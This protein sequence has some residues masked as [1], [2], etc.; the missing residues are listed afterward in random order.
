MLLVSEALRP[1]RFITA[2]RLIALRIPTQ[3]MEASIKALRDL[4]VTVPKI[5]PAVK[6]SDDIPT[7]SSPLSLNSSPTS[8]VDERLLLLHQTLQ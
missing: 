5:R 2:L 6:P 8:I 7:P 1:S 3:K 4:L